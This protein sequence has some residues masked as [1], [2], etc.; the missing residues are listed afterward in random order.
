MISSLLVVGT[1]PPPSNTH[2]CCRLGRKS[3]YTERLGGTNAGQL[4]FTKEIVVHIGNYY[5]PT[6]GDAHRL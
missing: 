6:S 1:R 4:V 3:D 5:F 2:R